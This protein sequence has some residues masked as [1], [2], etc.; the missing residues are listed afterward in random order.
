MAVITAQR[1]C[2]PWK[3]KRRGGIETPERVIEGRQGDQKQKR[4][5]GIETNLLNK[6]F[7]GPAQ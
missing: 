5:G 1:V 6:P 2:G 4:R 3:Q 7:A